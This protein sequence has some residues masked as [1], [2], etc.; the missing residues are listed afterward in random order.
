M[1]EEQLLEFIN[2][3]ISK[4]HDYETAADA[5]SNITVAAFNYAASTIGITGFQANWAG[6]TAI[7]E[8]LSIE[9][10]FAIVEGEKF[11]F[12]QYDLHKQLDD[13]HESWK[14]SL[15]E[16]AKEKLK[17]SDDMVHPNVKRRW[18][19]YANLQSEEKEE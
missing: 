17:E 18:E 12:P 15:S 4:Q 3:E 6:L 5:V 13:W 19:Y 11:L 8:I 16:M 14:H 2:T 10:P 7:R 9:G 1:N